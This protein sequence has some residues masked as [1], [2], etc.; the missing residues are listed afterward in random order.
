M[1]MYIQ[2]Q[3][4]KIQNHLCH[5]IQGQQ[6]FLARGVQ[7]DYGVTSPCLDHTKKILLQVA[8]RCKHSKVDPTSALVY[9]SGGLFGQRPM[10]SRKMLF[11]I[12]Y[13]S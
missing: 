9:E 5:I 12:D 6:N 11:K 7:L 1:V 10:S 13:F 8:V 2:K 3:Y 4:H